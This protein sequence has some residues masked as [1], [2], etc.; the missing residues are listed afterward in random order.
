MESAKFW[1]MIGDDKQPAPV[2]A[3]KGG[4][5]AEDGLRLSLFK[6]CKESGRYTTMLLEQQH[7]MD[8]YLSRRISDT[9]DNGRL[10]DGDS[11][12]TP[13]PLRSTLFARGGRGGRG[14][15]SGRGGNARGTRGGIPPGHW[16][17]HSTS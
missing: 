15:G 13:H 5:E 16:R 17:G 4:N 7:R 10:K 12:K 8:P 6:K 14:G 2:V 11:V 3:S 9:F 1:V